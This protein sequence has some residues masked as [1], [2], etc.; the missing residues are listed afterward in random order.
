MDAHALERKLLDVLREH[1]RG[2]H[3]YVCYSGGLDSALVLAACLRAGLPTTALIAIGPALA[4]DEK[5]EALALAAQLGAAVEELDAGE[6]ELAAYRANA[7]D[8]C[9]H[10]KTAL[11]RTA[12]QRARAR[13]GEVWLL[14]GTQHED[15]GDYRPGL[16]AA[17]EQEVFSPLLT[18][19]L[20]KPMIR[21]LAR[22]WRL[23]VAEKPA[24]PC[25][26]SRF[27]VGVEVTPERLRM[28]DEVESCLRAHGLWPARARFHGPV[29]RL[30]IDRRVMARALEEP[31][32]SEL[33]AT[34]RRV[35]FA[36]VALDI[37]GLQS[38]SLSHA[39]EEKP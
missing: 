1:A 39:L 33:E 7:G 34:A 12:A 17:D 20:D 36:F 31:N 38:G 30:E 10:C 22:H 21:A 25:L 9:Y 15:L 11:Y 13:H 4:V 8:R 28:V 27:P 16:K 37:S 23:P 29:V 18:V 3:A 24:S 6:T 35:G 5:R 14:N 2:R 32:R 26:A 19:G